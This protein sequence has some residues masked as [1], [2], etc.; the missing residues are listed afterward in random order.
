MYEKKGKENTLLNLSS[1][2]TVKAV[3][4]IYGLMKDRCIIIVSEKILYTNVMRN[5]TLCEVAESRPL[6]NIAF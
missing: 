5:I 4:L 2:H 3:Q 6:C 1:H